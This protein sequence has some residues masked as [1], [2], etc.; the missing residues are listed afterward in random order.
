MIVRFIVFR[1]NVYV[2]Y[3]R[4]LDLGRIAPAEGAGPDVLRGYTILLDVI[5]GGATSKVLFCACVS[6]QYRY[7]YV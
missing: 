7:T 5:N 1:L 6:A 2:L 3:K 4:Y